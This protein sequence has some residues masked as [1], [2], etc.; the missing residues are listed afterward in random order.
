MVHSVKCLLC[1]QEDLH[2]LPRTC[3]NVWVVIVC[4]CWKAELGGSLELSGHLGTDKLKVQLESLSQKKGGGWFHS[5]RFSI[6]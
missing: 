6:A 2:L 1:R 3:I 4:M 5:L